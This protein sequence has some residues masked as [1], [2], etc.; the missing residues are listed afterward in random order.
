MINLTKKILLMAAVVMMLIGIIHTAAAYDS[1][2]INGKEYRLSTTDNFTDLSKVEQ[3]AKYLYDALADHPEVRTYVYLINSSRTVNVREDI[4]AVPVVYEAIEKYFSKSTTD[5]LHL[6]SLEQYAE[7]YYTTDH[8]WNY[9]GS[10]AGYRQIIRMLLGEDEPLMEP[11]E[12]V[13]FPVKFNGSINRHLKLQDS[14]EL[15][16]VYRFDYPEMKIVINGVPKASYGNQQLYFDGKY[17][18]L[19]MINHYAKFYGGDTGIVHIETDRTDRGTLVVFSNSFS[20]PITQLLASHYHDLWVIDFRYYLAGQDKDFDFSKILEEGNV[21]VLLLGDGVFFS[22][23]N[24]Y[25]KLRL[26]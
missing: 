23:T 17:S 10:Y 7:Y 1:V 19:E 6:D 11:V 9:K 20:N 3:Q 15:F 5:Y 18:R 22:Q 8:H 13:T 25:H 26:K 14:K 12:E 16:T 2:E 4:S 21:Q 24:P